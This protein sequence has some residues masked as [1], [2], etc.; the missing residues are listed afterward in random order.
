M[1]ASIILAPL[2]KFKTTNQNPKS[3]CQVQLDSH[4]FPGENVAANIPLLSFSLPIPVDQAPPLVTWSKFA[5]SIWSCW[6][7]E[8]EPLEVR[9]LGTPPLQP[10]DLLSRAS[11]GICRGYSRSTIIGFGIARTLMVEDIGTM[12]ESE[13]EEFTRWGGDAEAPAPKQSP[14]ANTPTTQPRTSKPKSPQ[15]LYPQTPKLETPNPKKI[16]QKSPKPLN[17]KPP[18]PL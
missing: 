9:P 3:Q 8:R 2:V 6:E 17:P 10:G 14:K 12:P 11:V 5:A 1:Y 13:K 7:N 4:G 15:P 18:K 16:K